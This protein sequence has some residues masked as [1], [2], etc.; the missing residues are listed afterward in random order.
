M[1]GLLNYTHRRHDK[2][3]RLPF[4]AVVILLLATAT[5]YLVV[6]M[7]FSSST[8]LPFSWIAPHHD[9]ARPPDSPIDNAT[10]A[11]GDP[12][13][14]HPELHISRPPRTLRFEWSITRQKHR[15][16]G[17]LRDVYFIN[18]NWFAFATP[19]VLCSAFC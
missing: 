2:A 13:A 14:L 5:L 7:R 11:P 18:G 19:A 12:F 17:V 6:A 10:L 1:A 9:T 4:C 8:P 16:D 15:P 3:C